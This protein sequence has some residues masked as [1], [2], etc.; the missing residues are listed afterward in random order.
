MNQAIALTLPSLECTCLNWTQ[1]LWKCK[2]FPACMS[3]SPLNYKSVIILIMNFI[4]FFHFPIEKLA[5]PIE[6]LSFMLVPNHFLISTLTHCCSFI[7]TGGGP[8]CFFCVEGS[9]SQS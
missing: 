1:I 6:L 5:M 3:S 7:L 2:S 9:H 8:I 4:S